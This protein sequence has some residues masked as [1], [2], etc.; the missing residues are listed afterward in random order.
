M[1][2]QIYNSFNEIPIRK[3]I[4][5]WDLDIAENKI[6]GMMQPWGTNFDKYISTDILGYD[7]G[8]IFTRIDNKLYALILEN[9]DS[10]SQF[11]K[12]IFYDYLKSKRINANFTY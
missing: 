8:I 3:K 6:N 5:D 4:Y 11:K 1:S 2:F 10:G 9:I 7:D 12:F